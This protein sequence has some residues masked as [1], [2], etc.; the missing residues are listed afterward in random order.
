MT[1]IG[2]NPDLNYLKSFHGDDLFA[3]ITKDTWF[4][5]TNDMNFKT[6]TG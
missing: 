4:I 1:I 3:E 5:L 6:F 2:D